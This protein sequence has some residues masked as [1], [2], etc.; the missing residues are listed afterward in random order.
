MSAVSPWSGRFGFV[1]AASLLVLSACSSDDDPVD[2]DD[3]ATIVGSWQATSFT[4]LGTDYI[5]GGMTLAVTLSA[6]DTY[7]F[8]VT[9]D[10]VGVCEDAGPDCTRPGT[11]AATETQVTL[12]PG[13]EGEV[14]FDYSIVG[15]NMSWSGAIQGIPAQV[16]WARTD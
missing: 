3:D 15:S 4:A 2:P 10:E 16:T 13:T 8:T 6:S 9:G 1:V 14:T 7:T 12:D 11:Y 5:A